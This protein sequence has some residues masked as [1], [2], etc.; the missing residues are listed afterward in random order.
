VTFDTV[1]STFDTLLAVYVGNSV[2]NLAAV[3]GNDNI[4]SAIFRAASPLPPWRPPN[5]TSRSTAT[6]G[7]RQHHTQ[8]AAGAQHGPAP[9]ANSTSNSTS[10]LEVPGRVPD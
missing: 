5:I 2:D 8:L 1:G 3:A 10:E 7:L 6:A 9:G 4:G